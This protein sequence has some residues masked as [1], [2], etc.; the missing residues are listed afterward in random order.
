MNSHH[1][2]G[3]FRGGDKRH[4]QGGGGSEWRNKRHEGDDGRP[5]REWDKDR[6]ERKQRE[7]VDYDDPS[8]AANKTAHNAER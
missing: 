2:G 5:R 3:N 4:Y 8:N 1:S 7:Y 6:E